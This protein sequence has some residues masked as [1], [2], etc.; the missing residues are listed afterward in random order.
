MFS[1]SMCDILKEEHIKL[2]SKKKFKLHGSK[3][4]KTNKKGKRK[5]MNRIVKAKFSIF[6]PLKKKK[7]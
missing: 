4:R 1:F 2:L 7:T 6:L 5:T 3:Q